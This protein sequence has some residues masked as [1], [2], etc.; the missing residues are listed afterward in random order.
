MAKYLNYTGLQYFYNRLKETFVSD[1]TYA[2]NKLTKTK[3]G[4]S[5]DLL[6]VANGAEVNQNAFS[7]IKVGTST[8][9]ADTKTDTVEFVAGSN[10]T[11]TPDTTNDKI[12]I[13][14]TD[15]KYTPASASPKMDGTAAV[16]S[17]AKYAREDHV[18]PTDT[19]RVPTSRKVNGHALSADVTVSK[20]DV[21]LGNVDN[22]ADASKSVA[23]AA[24]LTT[25]REIDGLRFDGSSSVYRFCHAESGTTTD[26]SIPVYSVRSDNGAIVTSPGTIIAVSFGGG[27]GSGQKKLRVYNTA[28]SAYGD[29]F[30][31]YKSDG[32]AL[33]EEL[34]Q[35]SVYMFVLRQ[36]QDRSGWYAIGYYDE[37]ANYYAMTQQQATAGS[38]T[39][40]MLISPKVLST[41]IAN[42]VAGVT[43]ISYQIVTTLPTTGSAGVIYLVKDNSKNA[44]KEYIW[45]TDKYE[46]LGDTA[47]EIEAITN[48]EI[49][50]LFA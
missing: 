10:I 30:L 23:S 35:N 46:L 21:G 34:N 16:G 43:Q 42:A 36:D 49:D 26:G 8:V 27:A 50:S 32:N 15:T 12:T 19:S 48:A 13:A 31:M 40:S 3:G 11:L 24:K 37:R 38:S 20:S 6:T 17:S 47:I 33:D 45:I 5:T 44:Y 2:N 39:T 41:T 1:I 25:A 28:T 22:T 9:A 18:H 29:A 14:A 4:T 7:N